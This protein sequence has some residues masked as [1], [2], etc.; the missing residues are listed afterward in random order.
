[1]AWIE[2]IPR[3]SFS[4]FHCFCFCRRNIK[5]RVRYNELNFNATPKVNVKLTI[6]TTPFKVSSQ[7]ALVSLFLAFFLLSIE[8]SRFADRQLKFKTAK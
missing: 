8:I 1:M 3:N 7:M 2:V 4:L 6:Y 5:S